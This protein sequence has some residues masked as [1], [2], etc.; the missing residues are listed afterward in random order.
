M[1]KKSFK[2]AIGGLYRAK[3]IVIDKDGIHLADENN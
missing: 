1:S 3:L 2:S